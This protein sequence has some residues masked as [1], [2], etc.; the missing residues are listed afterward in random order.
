MNYYYMSLIVIALVFIWR[1]MAGFKRGM[2]RE[3]ISLIAMAVAGACV[4][5]ILGAIGNYMDKEIAEVL[6][7]ITVLTV[8]CL[9]YRLANVLLTSL[10]L[11]AGLPIVKGLDKILGVVIGFA[12][13]G[14]IVAMAIHVLKEWGLSVLR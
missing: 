3:V 10:Q 5:L 8:V 9:V 12:E 7:I 2:V 13:A 1:M 11:I 4:T 6:Q 14:I